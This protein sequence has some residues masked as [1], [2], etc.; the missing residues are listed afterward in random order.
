MIA[1]LG[2]TGISG[3]GLRLSVPVL[4]LPRER[5]YL[6]EE[7]ALRT[8]G[9]ILLHI[10][11]LNEALESRIMNIG[12]SYGVLLARLTC[13]FCVCRV[14]HRTVSAAPCVAADA[15]DCMVR[16]CGDPVG[17]ASRGAWQLPWLR[18]CARFCCW[19]VL[20]VSSSGPA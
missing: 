7:G 6:V 3:P 14:A 12:L 5:C 2:S 11:R 15:A 17:I 10:V 9:I 18:R 19:G 4:L 16:P 1:S 20:P 13:G 8:R